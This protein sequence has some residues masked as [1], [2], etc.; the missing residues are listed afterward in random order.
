MFHSLQNRQHTTYKYK[1]LYSTR[2]ACI[3]ESRRLRCVKNWCYVFYSLCWHPK[4]VTACIKLNSKY[5]RGSA[6]SYIYIVDV[7]ETISKSKYCT[8]IGPHSSTLTTLFELLS[9]F[10]LMAIDRKRMIV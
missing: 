4:Y 10:I 6:Y 3:D 9:C 7:L 1:Y 8:I 2:L 5:L